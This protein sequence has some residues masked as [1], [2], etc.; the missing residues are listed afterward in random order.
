MSTLY[1]YAKINYIPNSNNY[2]PLIWVIF[3][4][5]REGLMVKG[6]RLKVKG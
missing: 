3:G 5:A 4:W 6:E 1:F 2:K